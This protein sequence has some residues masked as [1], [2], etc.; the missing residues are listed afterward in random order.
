MDLLTHQGLKQDLNLSNTSPKSHPNQTPR[1]PCIILDLYIKTED[2]I[3]L[4]KLLE[5]RDKFPFFIVQMPHMSTNIPSTNLYGCIFLELFPIARC[6]L[7]IADFISSASDLF[8][9]MSAQGGN[10][11]TLT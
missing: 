5:Q 9:R 3:F 6:T 1:K 2:S 10:R 7:R 11:A 8:S 4:Y